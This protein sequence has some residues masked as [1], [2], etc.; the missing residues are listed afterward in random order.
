MCENDNKRRFLGTLMMLGLL[1]GS[2]VGG[3]LGDRLG[4]KRTM[5]LAIT[6]IAP[7]TMFS[8]F[9]PNY[10]TYAILRFVC[11][12]C[13]PLVWVCKGPLTL[14]LFGTKYRKWVIIAQDFVSA[15]SQMVLVL[16]IYYEIWCKKNT[17]KF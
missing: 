12:C 7:L 3:Q 16:I 8:G 15:L 5:L 4:R 13:L 14:E 1:V 9:S 17:K 2:L 10:V 6:L 11:C